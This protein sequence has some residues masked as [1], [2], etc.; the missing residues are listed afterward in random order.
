MGCSFPITIADT[1]TGVHNLFYQTDITVYPN[2]SA[3]RVTIRSNSL[4]GNT[5]QL[6]DLWG[7]KIIVTKAMQNTEAM[8]I[9]ALSSGVYFLELVSAN[10]IINRKKLIR[11]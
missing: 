11:L 9:K 1:S 5:I 6:V 10:V 8:N 3:D 4:A 2:P 7:R